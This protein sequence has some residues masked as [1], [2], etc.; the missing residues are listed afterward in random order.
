MAQD[1]PQKAKLIRGLSLTD[2]ILLLAGGIIGSGIFLTAKDIALSTRTPLLFLAVWLIGMAVTLLACFAFAEMGA[3]FPDAGGQYIYLREAFGEFAAFL[4]GWMIFT[5]SVAGTIA[6][7]GAGFAEYTGKIFPALEATRAVATLGS[8]TLTRGHLVAVTVIALQ[9]TINV[10]GVR[11]GAVLQNLAT[12]TKFGAIALFVVLGLAIGKGSWSHYSA[13]LPPSPDAPSLLTGIG[14]ALIAVFWAYD[15]WVYITWVSGEVMTPQRNLPRAMIFGLTIVGVIYIAINAVYLYALPLLNISGV[16]AV[17]QAAAVS[18]FSSRAAQWLAIM[19]AI[20]CFG[21]MASAIMTGARVYYAMAEDRVFF[22]SFATVSPRFHTPVVSLILQGVWSSALALSGR[23]D[24]LFTYVMFMMVLSYVLT[25][26]ALFVLRRKMPNAERPYRCTGYPWTPILY[27]IVGTIFTINAIIE[28]PKEAGWGTLIVL[29]GV[30]LYL[31]WK[32]ERRQEQ[33]QP[34]MNAN[35]HEFLFFV[36]LSEAKNLFFPSAKKKQV[37]RFA[38]DDK[39]EKSLQPRDIAR[40]RHCK[41]ET[42]MPFR[43]FELEH[44]QSL[45]E[46]TVEYNLADSTVQCTDVRELLRESGPE[47]LLDTALYYPH[48]NGT[49]LLRIASQYPGATE[50]NVLVTVG[51]AQANSVVCSA[52][53]EPGDEVIVVSPGYRQVWGMAQNL[54]CAVNEL[55]LRPETDWRPDLDAL[56]ELITSR[57]KLVSVVNPN[58]PTGAVL[59]E[60]EMRRIVDICDK[61]GAWLHADEVYRGTELSGGETL[62]FWGMYDKLICVNSMSKAYGLAGL[63]IGWAVAS[64]DMVESLWRRH[65]YAVISAAAPSMKLAEIALEEKKRRWLLER[66]K[67]LSRAGHEIVAEWTKGQNGAFSVKKAAATSI[68]FVRYHFDMPSFELAEHLRKKASVLTAPGGFLGLEG[69]LR[70]AVGYDQQK[71]RAAL[72]RIGAVAA[73]LSIAA[74]RSR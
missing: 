37:L 71:L 22:R 53:L 30:P 44:Y 21:A 8:F 34:R 36:I 11:R 17:A 12:W 39:R 1:T 56:R 57:T 29:A 54:G 61:A 51:A 65:E 28:R 10:F 47:P 73:E 23:Y 63:R 50:N 60:G 13:P 6:A 40:T 24:Q 26:A 72:E 48:V 27:I 31:Y 7:L 55:H 42:F 69:H 14:V 20:S 46:H 33:N 16:T 18:M 2:S 43:N 70:M 41:N 19:I 3:M 52:L 25:V 64:P 35:E 5:V 68:A 74:A 66:Q 38:Q 58:N 4:Y 67:E 15:G 45:Y 32:R 49:P 9:T 62:S 59:T